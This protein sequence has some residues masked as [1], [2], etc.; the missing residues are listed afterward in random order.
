VQI[1]IDGSNV[2]GRMRL[3]RESAESKRA[4]VA[5]VASF[6]RKER[7]KAWCFF[8]GERPASFGTSLGILQVL[9]SGQRDADSMI[10]EKSLQLNGQVCC[11]TSD[12]GLAA[13][14]RSRRCEVKPA[15]WLIGSLTVERAESKVS[16]DDWESYFS[17]DKN[18]NV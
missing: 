4:L 18:R 13:R 10:V 9:F 8:D 3:D 11:V 1:L 2:L 17:E 5:A 12:G 7:S 14:I 16:E 6:C 15:E